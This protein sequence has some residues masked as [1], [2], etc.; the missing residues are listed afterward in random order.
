MTEREKKVIHLQNVESPSLSAILDFM[1]TGKIDINRNNAQAIFV[2]A[3]MF[4]IAELQDRCAIFMGKE[5]HLSNCVGMYQLASLYHCVQLQQL[6]KDYCIEHIKQVT[7]DLMELDSTEL[8]SILQ[9]DNLNVQSEETVA[10]I[11]LRWLEWDID[12]RE[13]SLEL[14]MCLRLPLLS[15]DFID[16]V[17]RDN[18]ILMRNAEINAALVQ[19]KEYDYDKENISS[20]YRFGMFAQKMLV[21]AGGGVDSCSRSLTS[22]EVESKKSPHPKGNT[23]G[24][25]HNKNA[26]SIK[27]L[28][29]STPIKGET[30]ALRCMSEI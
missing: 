26:H 18:E 1:Y 5:L 25:W 17:L 15:E 23:G 30:I 21:F 12:H 19:H 2:T 13:A 24:V 14:M 10:E 7:E 22:F 8:I 16:S 9:S 29:L 27:M 4:M 20:L 28:S 6:A 11:L 3:S